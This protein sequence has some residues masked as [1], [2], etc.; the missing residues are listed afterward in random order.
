MAKKL[1]KEPLFQKKIDKDALFQNYF[2]TANE[3]LYLFELIFNING[4]WRQFFGVEPSEH[5]AFISTKDEKKA[6]K[7]V[8]ESSAWKQLSELYDYAIDGIVN[9]NDPTDIVIDGAEILSFL[10]TENKSHADEWEA[11]VAQGDGRYALDMGED[12]LIEKLAL[13]ANVDIRTVRNAISAGEMAAFK[14]TGFHPSGLGPGQYIENVS[15]RNWL[16]GRRGFKPTILSAESIG[17]LEEVSTP[18]EFAAYLLSQRKRLGLDTEENKLVV[19]HP[20]VDV[21]AISA[22]ETGVFKLPLDAVFPIADFYQLDRKVFLSC[23]MR[24]FFSE[25]LSSIR[26]IIIAE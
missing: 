11:V 2:E 6:K 10:K 7:N 9:D 3:I 12:I 5:Y 18:A 26:E 14:V 20:S 23:V 4:V 24:V 15:A 13:L 8:Q 21:N 16:H 17:K 22:I 1:D 19:F 25:Q